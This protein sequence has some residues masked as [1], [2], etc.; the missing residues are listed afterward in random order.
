MEDYIAVERNV[1]VWETGM[2]PY[3]VIFFLFNMCTTPSVSRS[4]ESI[5]EGAP[6]NAPCYEVLLTLSNTL[7]LFLPLRYLNRISE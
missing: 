3:N 5:A 4:R 2:C 6:N 7:S 1:D